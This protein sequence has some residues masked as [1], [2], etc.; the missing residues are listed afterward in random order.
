MITPLLWCYYIVSSLGLFFIKAWLPQLFVQQGYTAA[1]ASYWTGMTSILGIV[2][3]LTVG[4]F[5][6]KFG[7][8]KGAL[9]PFLC[10]VFIVLTGSMTGIMFIAVMSLASFFENGEHSILTSLAPNLY[11]VSIRSHADSMAI[12]IA[13]IGSIAG[14]LVGGILISMGMSLQ[15]LFFVVGAPFMLC[16]VCCYALGA[17]YEKHIAPKSDIAA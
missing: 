6:D 3:T 14:P 10:G 16:T 5:L 4:F 15:N 9:W 17:L 7:F 8:K 12:A 2:G 1:A 11:P 13:K